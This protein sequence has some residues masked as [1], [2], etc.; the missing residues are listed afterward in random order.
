MEN[1]K[2]TCPYCGARSP[3]GRPCSPECTAAHEAYRA[4]A[5]WSKRIYYITV[6]VCAVYLL[7]SLL[8]DA[9]RTAI[10][11][12][13]AVFLCVKHIVWPYS[14]HV[15]G[16]EKSTERRVRMTGIIALCLVGALLLFLYTLDAER[17]TRV[18]H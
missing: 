6:A 13:W 16:C 14:F 18:V 2:Q 8:P 15:V 9:L 7:R 17:V 4:R 3:L 12:V 10:I 5:V 1:Q 11:S